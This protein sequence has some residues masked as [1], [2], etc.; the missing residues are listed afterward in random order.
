M[1][2]VIEAAFKFYAHND[3]QFEIGD[4]IFGKS[5]GNADGILQQA[6]A[7]YFQVSQTGALPFPKNV[8]ARN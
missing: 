2:E 4:I 5:I 6:V 7:S 8:D 1:L 3:Y